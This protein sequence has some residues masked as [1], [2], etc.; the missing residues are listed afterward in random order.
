MTFFYPLAE[1]LRDEEW[2]S[3]ILFIATQARIKDHK[4]FLILLFGMSFCCRSLSS[5]YVICVQAEVIANV[6]CVIW[7]EAKWGGYD[8]LPPPPINHHSTLY[9]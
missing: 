4:A 6:I 5:I 1:P 9:I 8:Y 3:L 7:G 2:R